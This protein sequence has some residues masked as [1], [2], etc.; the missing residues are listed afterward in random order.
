MQKFRHTATAFKIGHK[1]APKRS[2]PHIM[3]HTIHA[4]SAPKHTPLINVLN[5]PA[6]GP[7]GQ[8]KAENVNLDMLRRIC[9]EDS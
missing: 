5:T 9:T 8:G 1:K 2:A 3:L 4:P 7:R 6:C